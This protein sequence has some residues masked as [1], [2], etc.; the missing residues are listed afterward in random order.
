MAQFAD[1]ERPAKKVTSLFGGRRSES[2]AI[3]QQCHDQ[4]QGEDHDGL[5]VRNGLSAQDSD[6]QQCCGRKKNERF[7][8]RR[9]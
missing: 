8:E 5:A 9:P 3:E 1:V 7:E 6:A 2:P 4:Q